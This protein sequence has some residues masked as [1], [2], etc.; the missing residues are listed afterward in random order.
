MIMLILLLLLIIMII[1]ILMMIILM[2]IIILAHI[3]MKIIK[4]IITLII[5]WL[6]LKFQAQGKGKPSS[7]QHPL[8]SCPGAA[9]V[10]TSTGS[11]RS[12]SWASPLQSVPRAPPREAPST[13]G[14][15]S[16]V[17]SGDKS[18]PPPK[19][20]TASSKSRRLVRLPLTALR[21][22]EAATPCGDHHETRCLRRRAPRPPEAAQRR[23]PLPPTAL[24]HG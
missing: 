21:G 3:I 7:P 5:I 19:S 2:M 18:A 8:P 1:I 22:G 17:S 23:K 11:R 16:P 20:W 14:T 15:S 6:R 12:P 13:R 10:A 4:H 24:G 9:A